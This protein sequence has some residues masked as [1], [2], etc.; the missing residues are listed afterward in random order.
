M[1]II[2]DVLSFAPLL[3]RSIADPEVQDLLAEYRV[4]PE[5]DEAD[6]TGSIDCSRFGFD[7]ILT[8]DQPSAAVNDQTSNT[9]FRVAFVRVFSP[10]YCKNK[11]CT[12]YS[13]VLLDGIRFPVEKETL[14]SKLGTPSETVQKVRHYDQYDYPDCSVRFVYPKHENHVVFVE[15]D[16]PGAAGRRS[17]LISAEGRLREISGSR[18][19]NWMS[20]LRLYERVFGPS[21][22]VL[23]GHPIGN[24]PTIDVLVFQERRDYYTLVTN[25][26][27]DMRMHMPQNSPDPPRLELEVYVK[28]VDENITHRLIQDAVFPFVERTYLGHGD[29]IDWMIPIVE[30]SKLT[31]DLLIYSI[32]T[33]HREMKLEIEGDPV[34]LLWVVPIT[35]EEL[36]YKKENGLDALLSVFDKVKHPMVLNVAR[37]SYV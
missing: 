8:A 10:H 36:V 13:G 25:G 34:Q 18:K 31:A 17:R 14:R 6:N 16:S 28:Q 5:I 12:G 3:G 27:S 24:I 32:L 20:R 37:P 29:T 15:I 21:T 33:K 7:V 30:G 23:T 1:I 35:S 11:P 19:A 4:Q 26:M 9:I 22:G 2:K